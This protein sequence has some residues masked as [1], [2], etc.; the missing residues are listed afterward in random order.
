[1]FMYYMA[2]YQLALDQFLDADGKKNVMIAELND[3]R[4]SKRGTERIHGLMFSNVGI[5]NAAVRFN[6]FERQLFAHSP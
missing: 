4:S 5:K 6:C 2:G 1:M 3:Y